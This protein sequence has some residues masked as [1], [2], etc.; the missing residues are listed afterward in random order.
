MTKDFQDDVFVSEKNWD[1]EV[2]EHKTKIDSLSKKIVNL[3]VEN[4]KLRKLNEELVLKIETHWPMIEKINRETSVYTGE[5]DVN[6]ARQTEDISQKAVATQTNSSL[7]R[8]NSS[9]TE[10]SYNSATTTETQTELDE[11]AI[12]EIL[13]LKAIQTICVSKSSQTDTSLRMCGEQRKTNTG[14]NG[15]PQLLIVSNIPMERSMK[16]F[17]EYVGRSFDI[18]SQYL[19]HASSEDI[20]KRTL[21]YSGK[22]SK[23]D[24]IILFM[25]SNSASKDQAVSANSLRQLLQ[26]IEDT[27]LIVVGCPKTVN[28]P[29]LNKFIA[30]VNLSLEK[31]LAGSK[32]HYVDAARIT[33][34]Q[35]TSRGVWWRA[36]SLRRVLSH[37]NEAQFFHR[38]TRTYEQFSGASPQ[39]APGVVK[40][41]EEFLRRLENLRKPSTDD[42][43]ITVHQNLIIKNP[44]SALPE[45][46]ECFPPQVVFSPSLSDGAR[47][48]QTPDELDTGW[49]P[50]YSSTQATGE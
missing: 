21:G 3:K 36:D 31:L 10:S 40:E 26:G 17:R 25:G 30:K 47:F 15:K 49:R 38:P 43:K 29:I 27:Q 46:S 39:E 4:A 41:N 8:N 13:L 24:R 12:E 1:E 18:N 34:P 2:T 5:I 22:L 11:N 7:S 6:Q 16:L 48:F 50:L 37:L 23:D 33:P 19:R 35:W 14:G 44:A 20:I 32:A 9:Q 42:K 45:E 28:R